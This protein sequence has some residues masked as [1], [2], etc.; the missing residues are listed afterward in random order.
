H[1]RY[2][3][4]FPTRRSSDLLCSFALATK[5]PAMTA[6]TIIKAIEEG[7][8]K[9]TNTSEKHSAFATLFARLFRSQFIA[10]LG[11]VIMAFAMAFLLIWII[12]LATG[13]NLTDTKWHTLLTDASPVH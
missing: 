3:H 4:S 7:I 8:K 13:I 9:Q 6:T 5:Q 1:H 2:L 12:D 11:N 10:F